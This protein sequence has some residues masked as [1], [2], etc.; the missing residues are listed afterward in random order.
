MADEIA[1]FVE[2]VPASARPR[3]TVVGVFECQSQDYPDN[4]ENKGIRACLLNIRHHSLTSGLPGTLSKITTYSSYSSQRGT[5]GTRPRQ[6]VTTFYDRILFFADLSS[7]NGQCFAMILQNSADSRHMF[8]H[9]RT[10]VAVGQCFVIVEPHAVSNSLSLGLP[11]VTTDSPLL[12]LAFR[13]QDVPEV[14]VRLPNMNETLYFAM[15][16]AEIVLSGVTIISRNVSCNGTL[17]DRQTAVP[18]DSRAVSCGCLHSPKEQGI[19]VVMECR[20]KFAVPLAFDE[21]GFTGVDSVRSWRLTKLFI[22]PLNAP[23]VSDVANN[24][25]KVTTFRNAASL[26]SGFINRNG[27]WTVVGWHRQGT[28][29]DH[30]SNDQTDQVANLQ[31]KLHI[32]YLYPTNVNI[33]QDEDFISLRYDPTSEE[34]GSDEEY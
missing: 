17:C 6:G 16:G 27:G 2:S 23:Q 11:L 31:Q 10:N 15:H 22:A 18:G 26:M 5:G 33:Q 13:V 3:L 28:T 24:R 30:S 21:S 14:P 12:P 20:V 32:C 34:G 29:V 4:R 8:L 7:R 19:S 25:M 9:A 1:N